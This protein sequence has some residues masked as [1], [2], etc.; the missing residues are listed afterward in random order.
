MFRLRFV[1]IVLLLA[2]SF[3]LASSLAAQEAPPDYRVRIIRAE[4]SENDIIIQFGVENIGGP[5]ETPTTVRLRDANEGNIL[6]STRIRALGGNGDTEADLQFTL[7]LSTFP[8]DTMQTLEVAVDV[9]EIGENPDTSL[10]NLD[11][12]PIIIPDYDA[13]PDPTAAPDTPRTDAPDSIIVIPIL[14]L[15]VDT[16]DPEQT[17]LLMGAA[18]TGLLMLVLVVGILRLLLR[19]TPSFG[20]WQPPYAT[21]PP[22]DPNSTYGRRQLWQQH[23]QSNVVTRPCTD[24][25]ACKL[26]LGTDGVYL[27]GWRITALRM[28]QY[29]MY[30][31]ITRSELLAT[32]GLLNKLNTI[33]RKAHRSTRE[34]TEHRLRPLAKSLARQFKKKVNKRSAMLPIALDVRFQGAHGEVRIIF[35]LYGCHNSQPTLLDSWEPEMTVLGKR[36]YESYTYTV[37][38]QHSGESYNDF[39]NRLAHDITQI[40][41]VLAPTPPASEPAQ[42]AQATS[43]DAPVTNPH[44]SP[45]NDDDGSITHDTRNNAPVNPDQDE[46]TPDD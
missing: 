5:A 19:R 15:E 42:P 9:S 10:N 31:R 2:F 25:Q 13:A 8:P 46:T 38:G 35:E 12:R 43:T 29:D 28:T 41:L 16:S 21:M 39:R 34:K 7:P 24:V 11:S 14:E 1:I 6:D 22:L 36:I 33:I 37:M 40:L 45:V 23:T 20:N 18:F 30:G 17:R 44:L 32:R 4:V 26:L 3:V 27:S